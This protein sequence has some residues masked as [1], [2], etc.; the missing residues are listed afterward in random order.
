MQSLAKAPRYVRVDMGFAVTVARY[1]AAHPLTVL[2]DEPAD[3]CYP[4]AIDASTMGHRGQ[5][6]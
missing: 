4:R 6:I 3:S 2:G 1:L 5:L